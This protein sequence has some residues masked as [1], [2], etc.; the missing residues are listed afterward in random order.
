LVRV[1]SPDHYDVHPLWKYY[2]RS[3]N[4]TCEDITGKSMDD[5]FLDIY[6]NGVMEYKVFNFFFILYA[7]YGAFRLL[8]QIYNKELKSFIGLI[9]SICLAWNQFSLFHLLAH[10]QND[11]SH[12]NGNVMHHSSYSVG[13]DNAALV[14][15]LPPGLIISFS[16]NFFTTYAIF[17][18]VMEYFKI[19]SRVYFNVLGPVSF[20]KMI[21][22]MAIIHP[23]IH[24][25]GRSWFKATFG[26]YFPYDEYEGHVKCHHVSGFCL[27]D[28]PLYSWF[29]N[30]LLY[31]HGEI[32]KAG[33]IKW[34]SRE[35]YIANVALDYFLVMSIIMFTFVTIIVF[36]PF[37]D[38]QSVLE[39]SG[40]K[41]VTA[42]KVD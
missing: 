24:T 37:M 5:Y 3:T 21:L 42:K 34:L 22:Q 1:S 7:G 27:G 18:A 36:Y 15:T 11:C 19:D 38:K 17:Y 30:T 4:S 23:F 40:S 10:Y 29:Y 12:I 39:T 16:L 25:Q 28:G 32:Y 6:Q 33:T 20:C 35:H 2:Q 26:P 8:Q 14:N 13:G 31:Y 9:A 41:R